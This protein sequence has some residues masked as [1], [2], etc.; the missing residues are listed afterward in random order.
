MKKGFVLFTV[1]LFILGGALV[2]AQDYDDYDDNDDFDPPYLSDED[3][4]AL[5]AVLPEDEAPV[6]QDRTVVAT[7]GTGST[8]NEMPRLNTSQRLYHLL[9]LDRTYSPNSDISDL[10]NISLL[11][12]YRH[13]RNGYLIA[14]Y[15]SP[16]DGPVF[17]Q[18]P[19]RSRIIVNMSSV[20]RATLREYINSPAFRRFVSN[21]TLISQ[22][23]RVL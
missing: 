5:E 13:G 9:I 14:I 10:G 12:R 8:A 21:R 18:L 16:P 2:F 22:M 1:V 23:L 17:P 15:V 3:I 7:G 20:R 19:D 4:L 6:F 11:Y